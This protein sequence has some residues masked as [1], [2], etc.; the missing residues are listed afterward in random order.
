LG[1][2][3]VRVDGRAV[4]AADW[5]RRQAAALVKLL[6]LAP[7]RTLH[8]EQVID[9]LWPELPIEEAAPRLHKA[10]HYAR[11]ALGDA[12]A[13]VLDGN[14]VSLFPDTEV[15]IDAQLFERRTEDALAVEGS[16]DNDPD[17]F[18]AAAAAAELWTG[19]LLPDDPYEA[20]LELPRDRLR[21]LHHEM[22][23][24]ADR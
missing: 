22:L 19:D 9:A 5:R 24:R 20:W 2:F 10:A 21:Q 23:R 3:A 8:R 4:P 18:S 12:R 17:R 11:R 1:D 13:L 14:T 15:I 6:A 16:S 7:R